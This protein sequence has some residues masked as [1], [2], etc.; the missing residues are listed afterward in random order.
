M[1]PRDKEGCTPLMKAAASGH[2]E[3]TSMLL[4]AGADPTAADSKGRVAREHALE[5]HHY[6]V[7]QLLGAPGT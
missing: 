4:S 7:A 3:I 5:G 1:D 6:E 2:A